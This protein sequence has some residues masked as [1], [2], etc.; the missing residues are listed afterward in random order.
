MSL[1]ASL[2]PILHAQKFTVREFNES[3]F[4][5]NTVKFAISKKT[6]DVLDRHRVKGRKEKIQNIKK[7][8]RISLHQNK[9]KRRY[10]NPNNFC[11]Y[12]HEEIPR[13]QT[14]HLLQHCT[15]LKSTPAVTGKLIDLR[16][17]ARR[18]LDIA[19]FNAK[20]EGRVTPKRQPKRKFGEGDGE[21]LAETT[22]RRKKRPK[23]AQLRRMLN[24]TR[25]GGAA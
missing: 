17:T 5:C 21:S 8:G 10:V 11:R 2:Q 25:P 9:R 22:P 6:I 14:H 1:R 20:L 15:G 12:C 7:T 23:L 4:S 13:H 16:A 19:R 18:C 3:T 24:S